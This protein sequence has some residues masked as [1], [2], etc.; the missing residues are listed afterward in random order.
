MPKTTSAERMRKHCQNKAN[1]DPEFKQKE[2]KTISDLLQG[3]QQCINVRRRTKY[4]LREKQTKTAGIE[5]QK[6][7][8]RSSEHYTSS[9]K[10][11]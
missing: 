8:K 10:W 4:S 9:K 6:Q 3:Q 5:S 11:I 1:N 7:S 2:T